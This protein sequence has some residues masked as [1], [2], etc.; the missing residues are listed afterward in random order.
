[1]SVGNEIE[2][3]SVNQP[4]SGRHIKSQAQQIYH[5]VAALSGRSPLVPPPCLPPMSSLKQRPGEEKAN[6]HNKDATI[7]SLVLKK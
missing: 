1:M 5:T 6:R 4:P 7:S 3:G 2:E